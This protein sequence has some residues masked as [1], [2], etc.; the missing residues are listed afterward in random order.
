MANV[1]Y[2]SPDGESLRSCFVNNSINIKH[3]ESSTSKKIVKV[4]IN[5]QLLHSQPSYSKIIMKTYVVDERYRQI[6]KSNKASAVKNNQNKE[7]H[8]I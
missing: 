2:Q 6:D 8:I 1:I 7:L 3:G 4:I 5:G